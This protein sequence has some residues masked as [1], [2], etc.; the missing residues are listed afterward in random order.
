MSPQSD[1]CVTD[2]VQAFLTEYLPHRRALSTR[3]IESYGEALRLLIEFIATRDGRPRAAVQLAD[4]S[5]ERIQAFLEY[6]ERER[7]NSVHSRNVRLAAVRCFLR[8]AAPWD[9]SPRHAVTRALAVPM[10]RFVR[11]QPRHLSDAQ[12][13]AIIGTQDGSWIGQRDH[14]LLT[15]LYNTAATVSEI[16]RLQVGQIELG[17]Q[18]CVCFRDTR[19]ARTVPLWPDTVQ[20]IERWLA[21]NPG[22]VPGSIL[23]PNQRGAGMTATCVR[24][25]L[26]IAVRRAAREDPGLAQQPISPRSIRHTASI[27]LL[28]RGTELAQITRWLGHDTP[29]TM[30]NHARAVRRVGNRVALRL[31]VIDTMGRA[32]RSVG[33][34]PRVDPLLEFDEAL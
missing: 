31:P 27:H 20:G 2:L 1:A 17:E 25:R 9:D 10:K 13:Q 32:A 12:M 22:L 29:A 11:R 7:H 14:L 15:L 3:T 34:P 21:A 23:L 19:H 18:P 26:A 16:V 4:L 5:A 33:A 28:Q 24:R 30:H 8:F 6:L